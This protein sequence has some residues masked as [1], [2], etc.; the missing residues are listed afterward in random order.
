MKTLFVMALLSIIC[1]RHSVANEVCFGS[2]FKNGAPPLSTQEIVENYHKLLDSLGEGKLTP[3]ILKKMQKSG[4]PF[5]LPDELVMESSTL[6][7][8]L[9]ELKAYLKEGKEGGAPIVKEILNSLV[10]SAKK[11]AE[12]DQKQKKSDKLVLKWTR[13]NLHPDVRSPGPFL[14]ETQFFTFKDKKL[15]LYDIRQKKYVSE[16]SLKD[17]GPG[18]ELSWKTKFLL[19]PKKDL[20]VIVND[21][22]IG[23]F[24]TQSSS[25]SSG[26]LRTSNNRGFR[27]AKLSQDG[28]RLFLG[29]EDGESIIYQL[30]SLQPIFGTTKGDYPHG[31]GI[32]E[33]PNGQYVIFIRS[34]GNQVLYDLKAKREIS[35]PNLDEAKFYHCYDA[36]FSKDSNTI[37]MANHNSKLMDFDIA[38]GKLNPSKYKSN[39]KHL[40]TSADGAYVIIGRDTAYPEGKDSR[41]FTVLEASSGKDVTPDLKPFDIDRVAQL[42]QFPEHSKI[43]FQDSGEAQSYLYMLDLKSLD[44]ERYRHPKKPFMMSF[45]GFT[46]DGKSLLAVGNGGPVIEVY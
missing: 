4:D 1:A 36:I 26:A 31:N 18:Q 33:S 37:T 35:L 34:D 44:V 45:A 11:H 8:S 12:T 32:V 20:L 22:S 5:S 27:F 23:L 6:K 39:G 14:N 30:P 28:T 15:A 21:D 41:P 42:W 10:K 13:Q 46:P 9:A 19:T 16:V 2:L 17:G 24:N 40:F 29:G 43:V 7:D 3:A 25:Y 38:T